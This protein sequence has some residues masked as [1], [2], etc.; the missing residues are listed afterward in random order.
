MAA[1]SGTGG[2]ETRAIHAGQPPDPTSGAVMV[3]IY[4]SSTFA[5]E[6][7][8][9]HKG[10][11]YA[12]TGNPTRSA[13]EACLASLEGA[14][15]GF[16]FASG[17]AAEDAVLRLLEPG[18]HVVI[19]TD[20]YGGTWRLVDKVHV[21]AGLR[22]DAADLTSL[23]GLA[24]AWRPETKMVWI[25]T[26]SNP[27]LSIVDIA[28]VA[29]FAAERGAR[30]VVDN[31][32][33][34]PYLQ[35][36]LAL[37]ADVVVHSTTKYLGGHSDVVGGFAGVNDGAL[38]ERLGF[39]QNAAGAVPGPMDCFLTMRGVKTLGVRMDRHCANAA[40]VVDFLAG[41]P[42]V[43]SVLW[44][45]RPSHPGHEVALRQMRHFG[46]MV[47]FTLHGGSAAAAGLVERTEL[48]TLAESLGGVE[49]LIEVP[50]LMT[51]L[52]VAGSTN[53][54]DPGLVRLSVGIE[55]VDDIVA[56]LRQALDSVTGG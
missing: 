43:A 13:L 5:Q 26:P 50:A 42:A 4:Q 39:L 44:P 14:A 38:A 31:T 33:A 19:P 37:G 54:V 20:A 49:S 45:G 6:G 8:G 27:L 51:H 35:T 53:E 40:A 10:Y 15:F 23:D 21:P 2:F 48:V 47:S 3:P 1:S 24:A 46:G 41:H 56:D 17:M 32:F 30:T 9:R 29:A 7:I 11:E 52:S 28:A 25:E 18:D 36:P 12:R 16:C 55:T 34:T 22:Y